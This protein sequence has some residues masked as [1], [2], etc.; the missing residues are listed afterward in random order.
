MQWRLRLPAGLREDGL[1]DHRGHMLLLTDEPEA[2]ELDSSGK[3][4]WSRKLDRSAATSPVS[5]NSGARLVLTRSGRLY[6]F[7]EGGID[8]F[9][10]RHLSGEIGRL[11]AAPIAVATGG[12]LFSIGHEAIIVDDRG[13]VSSSTRFDSP[14]RWALSAF[15]KHYLVLDDGRVVEWHAHRTRTLVRLSPP[16]AQAPLLDGT[17]LVAISG[18]RLVVADVTTGTVREVDSRPSDAFA[19]APARLSPGHVGVLTRSGALL[20]YDLTRDIATVQHLGGVRVASNDREVFELLVD[21]TGQFLVA[22]TNG[23]VTLIGGGAPTVRQLECSGRP[24][25][26]PYAPSRL[27]YACPSGQLWSLGPPDPKP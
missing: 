7:G 20:G 15:G 12:A 21:D 1:V 24:L 16:P 9:S 23:E 22:S 26:L 14:V 27:L 2:K 17:R 25:L 8:L 10:P 4:T 11:R 18:D 6:G 3:R 13:N 19:S 5:T